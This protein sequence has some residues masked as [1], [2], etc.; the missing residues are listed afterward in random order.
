LPKIGNRLLCTHIHDNDH[1]SDLHLIP[2]DGEIDFKKMCQELKA[3]NYEG[4][5]TLEL[6][7]S[8]KYKKELDEYD[9]VK[10]SFESAQKIKSLLSN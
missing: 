3:C 9:F 7:Y 8:E 6:C 5:I 1:K 4:N 2:F 10:K